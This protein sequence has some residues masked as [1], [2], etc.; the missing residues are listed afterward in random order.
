M[1]EQFMLELR[2]GGGEGGGRYTEIQFCLWSSG[3]EFKL[4]IDK[5]MWAVKLKMFL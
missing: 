2:E 5:N 4:D 3:F 1:L